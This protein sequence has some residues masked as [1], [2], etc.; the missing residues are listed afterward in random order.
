MVR[1]T[2]HAVGTMLLLAQLCLVAGT[3]SGASEARAAEF[4]VESARAAY[5]EGEFATCARLL[6][7]ALQSQQIPAAGQREAY[8][9]LA[10]AHVQ[11]GQVEAARSA[12]AHLLD[13]APEWRPDEDVVRPNEVA[14]FR[15]VLAARPAA[16]V[17]TRSPAGK[18][19][20]LPAG[21]K[22]AQLPPQ[23]AS[24]VKE[25]KP[26]L[27]WIAGGIGCAV[28]LAL[29]LG[30]DKPGEQTSAPPGPL[31]WAPNPPAGH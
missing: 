28:G 17:D 8:E 21:A 29:A 27:W 26:L 2:L 14:L 22:P 18:P 16:A 7:A 3:M 4:V 15:E 9:F 13:L 5:R 24:Q 23:P 20:D 12:F 19:V 10:R 30:G 31:P 1:R 25:R 6:E 11:L